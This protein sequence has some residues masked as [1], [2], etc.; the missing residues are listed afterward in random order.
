MRYLLLLLLIPV[1]VALTIDV[2]P[3]TVSLDANPGESRV[4]FFKA[5]YDSPAS[6]KLASSTPWIVFPGEIHGNGEFSAIL[7]VPKEAEPGS[8]E[9]SIWV[10]TSYSGTVKSSGSNVFVKVLGKEKREIVI[11]DVVIERRGEL[12]F[13]YA[14]L[15]NNGTITTNVSVT[16]TGSIEASKTATIPPATEVVVPMYMG[17]LKNGGDIVVI[18]QWE[19]GKTYREAAFEVPEL[20]PKSENGNLWIGL[21]SVILLFMI[22]RFR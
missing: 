22:T 5:A 12:E 4:L 1:A 10:E 7:T 14:R 20:I 16:G 11:T 9:F 8:Y 17:K 15:L 2:S 18:A 19:G 21:I 3:Q 6:G 13:V